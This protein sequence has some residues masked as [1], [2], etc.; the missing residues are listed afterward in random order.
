M[1]GQQRAAHGQTPFGKI[2]SHGPRLGDRT[3]ISVDEQYTHMTT[4]S[5][6]GRWIELRGLWHRSSLLAW[7]RVELVAPS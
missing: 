7:E 6:K 2:D 1:T 5:I 4:S 3:G